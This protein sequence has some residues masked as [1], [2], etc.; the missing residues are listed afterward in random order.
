MVWV[1]T[2]PD[3]YYI[4]YTFLQHNS[5]SSICKNV[6]NKQHYIV[7]SQSDLDLMMIVEVV[8]NSGDMMRL[9]GTL[10]TT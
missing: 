10:L 4:S 8:V 6:M 2:L 5:L 7:E 1:S 3:K 9:F